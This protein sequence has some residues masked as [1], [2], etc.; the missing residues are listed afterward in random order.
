MID[1]YM[2]HI[3]LSVLTN[4]CD[5]CYIV[6]TILAHMVRD[7]AGDETLSLLVKLTNSGG[8]CVAARLRLRYYFKVLTSLLVYARGR[9]KA[10]RMYCPT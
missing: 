6:I 9:A 5:R 4:R 1:C 2:Y 3:I 8:N 7:T 10:G